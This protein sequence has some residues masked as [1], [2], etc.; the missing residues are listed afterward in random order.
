M[1]RHLQTERQQGGRYQGEDG[2]HHLL[3]DVIF[4]IGFA[5]LFVGALRSHEIL[6][7]ATDA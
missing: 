4:V 3:L 6:I 5:P 2:F 1:R 7:C